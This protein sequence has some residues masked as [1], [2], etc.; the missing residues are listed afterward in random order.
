MTIPGLAFLMGPWSL[1]GGAQGLPE[2][3]WVVLV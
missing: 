2:H 1:F 3:S